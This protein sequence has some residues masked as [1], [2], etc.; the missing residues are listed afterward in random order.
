M[1]AFKKFESDSTKNHL[2]LSRKLEQEAN[3]NNSFWNILF[4]CILGFLN[5]Y[6]VKSD[7]K[8]KSNK[9]K[10]YHVCYIP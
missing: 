6:I 7:Q 10:K 4:S 3:K 8:F 9:C 5:K 1:F 2:A